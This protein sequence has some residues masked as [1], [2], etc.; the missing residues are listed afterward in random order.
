MLVQIYSKGSLSID[1]AITPGKIFLRTNT[2]LLILAC[3]FMIK[4]LCKGRMFVMDNALLLVQIRSLEA[5]LA[6]LRIRLKQ[7]DTPRT[8]FAAYYGSLAKVQTTNAE[9]EASTLK[10]KVEML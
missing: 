6:V 9:I 3:G 1:F 10:S 4:V 5:Q 8:S 2:Q 7:S